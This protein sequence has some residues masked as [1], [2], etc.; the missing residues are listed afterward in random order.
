MKNK[1]SSKKVIATIVM[2]VIFSFILIFG[3]IKTYAWVA[4]NLDVKNQIGIQIEGD[5]I[6]STNF[7]AVKYDYN[8]G[9][10]KY[11]TEDKIVIPE[12]DTV[13]N[14]RNEKSVIIFRAPIFG[15]AVRNG[16]TFTITITLK[17]LGIGTD[18]NKNKNLYDENDHI[19][20]YVSNVIYIKVAS[21]PNGSTTPSTQDELNE[22]FDDVHDYF[23]DD[24]NDIERKTFATISDGVITKESELSFSLSDYSSNVD[25]DGV[26]YAFIEIGYDNTLINN[27]AEEQNNSS[28]FGDSDGSVKIESDLANFIFS[29]GGGN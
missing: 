13:F 28:S 18:E 22:F 25:S 10:A 21:V 15:P 23:S 20:S 7:I 29:V 9:M 11:V 19:C 17:D 27:F 16:E 2:S 8:D 12:Y 3:G 6:L 5:M 26:L 14:E 24:T 1:N 4:R